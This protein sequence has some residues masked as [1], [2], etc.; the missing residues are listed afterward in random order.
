[1][2]ILPEVNLASGKNGHSSLLQSI[3]ANIT[4][5]VEELKEV[6]A[7][8]RDVKPR[9]QCDS[10]T[11]VVNR[12]GCLD[13]CKVVW[14]ENLAFKKAT[15]AITELE[16][17][18]RINAKPDNKLFHHDSLE[19]KPIT[20][21]LEAS[22]L[23]P[24]PKPNP[25]IL[26]KN[27]LPGLARAKFTGPVPEEKRLSAG[28]VRKL[29]IDKNVLEH[30]KNDIKHDPGISDALKY[31]LKQVADSITKAKI[32]KILA[33]PNPNKQLIGRNFHHHHNEPMGLDNQGGLSH[34]LGHDNSFSFHNSND[35]DDISPIHVNEGSNPE[36]VAKLLHRGHHHHHNPSMISASSLNRLLHH[37]NSEDV[38]EENE[39][40]HEHED[41]HGVIHMHGS[42][43]FL[44]QLLH[45][46]HGTNALKEEDE[47]EYDNEGGEHENFHDEGHDED[48]DDEKAVISKGQLMKLLHQTDEGDS[49]HH[50]DE[51]SDDGDDEEYVDDDNDE[52]MVRS[53]GVA[54]KREYVFLLL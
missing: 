54:L 12:P 17:S 53:K 11:K 48:D 20:K 7:D 22:L 32:E 16:N 5:T 44:N 40:Q 41:S 10:P 26:E 35:E 25:T 39:D 34:L 38:D 6:T 18:G 19:I 27:L 45:R 51:D 2:P 52:H 14:R 42:S 47:D 36:L 3:P 4:A 21:V 9:C 13:Y 33:Q 29:Q 50:G 15:H 46:N 31:H 30:V 1:M 28:F 8:E 37:Q 49:H 43:Q 24:N 23:N